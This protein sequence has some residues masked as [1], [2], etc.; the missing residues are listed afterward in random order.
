M[1][2]TTNYFFN[3][4]TVGGSE[5]TWGDNL[6]ENWA[7][8]DALLYGNSYTDGDANTVERIRPDLASGWA[9]NGTAITSTAD[10]LN[11]LD[12]VTWSLTGFNSLTATVAELNYM[13]GVTSNVQDQFAALG[14]VSTYSTL[15]SDWDDARNSGFF[16]GNTSTTS[17]PTSGSFYRGFVS[18]LSADAV[19]QIVTDNSAEGVFT[20]SLAGGSWTDWRRIGVLID[21]DDMASDSATKVPSQ[22]S[23]KAYVDNQAFGVGQ[24]WQ[25]VSGSRAVGTSYQ[26]TTGKAIQVSVTAVGG[27]SEYLQA[28]SDGSTWVDVAICLK[29]AGSSLLTTAQAIIPPG[30]YYRY[31]GTNTIQRWAELR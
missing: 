24:T 1:T 10:E 13:D 25:D 8:L 4:P 11:L 20:R 30:H 27:S 6:N 14:D 15:V 2:D 17:G 29:S 23:V 7:K 9:I 19:T 28:S 3:R 21:E 12:G 26:N 22:Q 5:D 18:A 31:D 16:H